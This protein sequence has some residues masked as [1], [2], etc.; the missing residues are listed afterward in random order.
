MAVWNCG[1]GNAIMTE[2][3]QAAVSSDVL[4]RA[5]GCLVGLGVGNALG[6]T[7]EFTTSAQVARMGEPHTEIVGGG[8][9]RLPAGEVSEPGGMTMALAQSLVE[10]GRLD[11]ADAALR[12]LAWFE[13]EPRGVDTTVSEAMR[14]VRRGALPPETSERVHTRFGGLTAGAGALMRCVPL[15]LL[16]ERDLDA[17]A[18]ASKAEARITHWDEVAGLASAFEN[19]AVARLVVGDAFEN[20]FTAAAAQVR[21]QDGRMD[22]LLDEIADGRR[23]RTAPDDDCIAVLHAAVW[24]VLTTE[25][26]ED[27]L[28]AAVNLGGYADVTG[29]VAGAIAGARYGEYAIPQRW[30]D[31]LRPLERLE[32]LAERLLRIEPAKPVTADSAAIG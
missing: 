12:Y 27:A 11:T 25:S 16:Y 18:T 6:V 5:R 14:E 31:A 24:S 9:F 22:A 20:A 23:P 17:L 29:A 8:P 4:D 21:G 2:A 32:D 10:L 1:N 3:T 26:L 13:E 30:L 7:L 19:V 28:V 15:A